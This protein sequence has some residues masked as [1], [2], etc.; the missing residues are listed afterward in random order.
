MSPRLAAPRRLRP[1]FDPG[2]LFLI[3]GLALLAATALITA[4]KE[5]AQARW[6]R[7]RVLAAESHRGERLARYE[8][9][10][11][12]LES[13]NPTLV[14][15][16]AGSQLNQIPSERAAIPGTVRDHTSDAGVFA[17]LEPPALRLP[18]QRSVDSMLS[19]L[20]TNDATRMW[21]LAASALL[22][23]I[24]LLPPSRGWSRSGVLAT[25]PAPTP[26]APAQAPSDVQTPLVS[27]GS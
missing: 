22:I 9:Y 20:V 21:M 18:S 2:W 10:M 11:G 27:A 15:S 24:G 6:L 3:A 23:L 26:D 1:L 12:A 16:L 25:P 17:A 14:E 7:D 13:R 4:Q 5:V 19:K 8:E